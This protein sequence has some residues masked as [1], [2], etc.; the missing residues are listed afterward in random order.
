MFVYFIFINLSVSN[1]VHPDPAIPVPFLS[2][3]F[4]D[5]YDPVT[6]AIRTVREG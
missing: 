3:F 1:S 5:I 4:S 2:N 6:Y